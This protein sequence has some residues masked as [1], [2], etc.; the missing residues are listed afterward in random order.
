MHKAGFVNIIGNPNVGKSTLMNGL[1]GEKL[2]IAT[3]KAQTTRH[4][5][6]GILSGEDYQIVFSDTPG[7]LQPKYKLQETM[8]KYVEEALQDADLLL[9]VTDPHDSKKINQE[10]LDKIKNLSVPIIVAV[11]KIDTV[12]QEEVKI[13]LE[14]WQKL[15]P[16][17]EIVPVSALHNFN[18]DKIM[19][20]IIEKLPVSPPYFEKDKLTDK[21]MRFFIAE[22]I[23]EKIFLNFRQEIPYSTQVVVE[24][25]KE[26]PAITK[27][28]AII[29]V[30]RESQKPIIIGNKG[31]AIKKIG[32]EARKDI[33]KFIDSK[34]YL[35][36]YV[37]VD[38]EWRNNP[39]KLR[40]F[41]Y[42]I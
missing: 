40:R 30:E 25:Y 33:E 20:L 16:E 10:Y 8:L 22:I 7:I 21:P 37:K 19:S 38:K 3:S 41:G 31:K 28:R 6:M 11:N 5:I 42:E 39:S 36:L 13:L 12:Q 27:I 1:I 15:L 18:I 24:E 26:F 14:Q 2:S 17:A 9:Y 32:T 4:R 35:E 34:V 29:Y 23:R